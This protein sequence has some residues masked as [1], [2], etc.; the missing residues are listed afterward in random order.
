M[1]DA[2]EYVVASRAH[3]GAA[4]VLKSNVVFK[5]NE[6]EDFA[7]YWNQWMRDRKTATRYGVFR[8]VPADHYSDGEDD[9]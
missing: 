3:D 5:K 6:A 1:A 4:L 9:G 8:L 7:D 2:N